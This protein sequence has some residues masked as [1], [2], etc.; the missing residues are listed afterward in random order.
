MTREQRERELRELLRSDG[1]QVKI[2]DLY[3]DTVGIPPG[4]P[5]QSGQLL[6]GL[7]QGILN[8]EFPPPTK[9][10]QPPSA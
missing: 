1:G 10:P 5:P 4:T 9:E 3:K 7:L 6:E 8:A 2:V